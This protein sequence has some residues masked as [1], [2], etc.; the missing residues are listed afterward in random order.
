MAGGT[1][2]HHG[3]VPVKFVLLLVEGETENRFVKQILGP[4]L[5]PL[6]VNLIPT[7]A[8]TRRVVSAPDF[9]GGIT[10][11]RLFR[12]ELLI[13][14]QNTRN[15]NHFDRLLWI[16]YRFPWAGHLPCGATSVTSRTHRIG[17]P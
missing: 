11:Y 14:L 4:A 15:D 8:K 5:I 10:N 12:T 1:T 9:K 6:N 3:W 13:L 17:S 7:V 16:A 2:I